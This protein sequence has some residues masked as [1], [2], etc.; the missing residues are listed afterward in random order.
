MI[1][2]TYL[3]KL[4]AEFKNFKAMKTMIK[5]NVYVLIYLVVVAGIIIITEV[6]R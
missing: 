2:K 4:S 5:D 1:T 6:V 3:N